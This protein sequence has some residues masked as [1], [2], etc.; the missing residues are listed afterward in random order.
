MYCFIG[1][2][3]GIGATRASKHTVAMSAG[4]VSAHEG[5]LEPRARSTSEL[6]RHRTVAREPL[7]QALTH[8][9]SRSLF[10]SRARFF[11]RVLAGLGLELELGLVCVVRLFTPLLRWGELEPKLEQGAGE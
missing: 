4:T 8:H 9:S 10:A 1:G 7:A 3:G 6:R 2:G 5:L 11:V